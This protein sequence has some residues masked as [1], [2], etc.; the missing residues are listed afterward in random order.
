MTRRLALQWP[1]PRPFHRLGRDRIRILAVSDE[2]D[3]TLGEPRN[4]ASLG[5]IDL[6]IGC[7]DLS[8]DA[9]A[10]VADAFG[11]PL[12]FVRGNHDTGEGWL[13]KSRLLPAPL[14]SGVPTRHA[15]VLIVGFPWAGGQI[16]ARRDE[17]GGWQQ[18]LGVAARRL[19]ARREPMLV[20][21]HAAPRG[22]GDGSRDA[23]HLG[24][25]GYRW[26]LDRYR[27]PLW[28]HGHTPL[29]SGEWRVECGRTTVVNVTGSV[30]VE[31]TPPPGAR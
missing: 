9:L 1:D 8:P 24:F 18:A 21:S 5:D 4:R 29:T 10:F 28:L 12:V 19:L 13:V 31:L 30:L 6:V 26:I 2:V 3:P 7:G 17:L 11:A 14:A 27:P 16:V 20:A 22:A 15:G 23:Y 25:Q